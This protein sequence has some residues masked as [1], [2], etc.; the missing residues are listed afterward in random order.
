MAVLRSPH[1]Q[2]LFSLY[3]SLITCLTA[4]KQAPDLERQRDREFRGFTGVV[5]GTVLGALIWLILIIVAAA[6]Y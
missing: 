3:A 4:L 1:F 6:L 5:V 2:T